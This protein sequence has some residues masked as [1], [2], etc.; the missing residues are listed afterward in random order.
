M[1]PYIREKTAFTFDEVP[2]N[3]SF[4]AG[5]LVTVNSGWRSI[6]PVVENA[7]CVGCEQCYLYCPDGVISI[8]DGKAQIDYDFCKGCGICA[9]ICRIGAIG[10]E[11]ER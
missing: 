3:T 10:M 2:V 7:K 11:A 9:K 8:K 6:R 1:R 5:Y 4:E